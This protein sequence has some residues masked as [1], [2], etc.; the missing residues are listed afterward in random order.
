M[1]QAE[2]YLIKLRSVFLKN[3][4]RVSEIEATTGNYDE[5]AKLIEKPVLTITTEFSEIGA[6]SDIIYFT[7]VLNSNSYRKYFFNLIKFY[8][9]VKIYGFKEFKIIFYPSKNFNPDKFEKNIKKEKYFQAQFT[10]NINSK[11]PE[12]LLKEYLIIRDK[13]I[14]S[15]VKN[16]LEGWAYNGGTDNKNI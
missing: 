14:S 1:T 4:L 6:Y 10:Y 11:T 15:G 8:L 7:F 5:K 9:N 12:F 3:N 2:K 13:I 16:I